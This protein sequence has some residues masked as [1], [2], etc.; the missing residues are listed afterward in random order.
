MGNFV[1][2]IGSA[3]LGIAG[4]ALAGT[5]LGATVLHVRPP[6]LF[7]LAAMT[8]VT[9]AIT[10]ISAGI[11]GRFMSPVK[12]ALVG[13]AVAS[14]VPISL[15]ASSRNASGDD[16]VFRGVAAAIS[17]VGIAGGAAALIGHAL[18]RH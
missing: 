7:G 8:G 11:A 16:Q 17:G 4:G 13:A 6:E 1:G 15:Y 5:A 2:I 10:G 18:L 14:L 3:G 9:G 12:A